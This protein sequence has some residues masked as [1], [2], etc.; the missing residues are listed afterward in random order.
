MHA[1]TDVLFVCHQENFSVS[2]SIE[3]ICC[4]HPLQ[5][6]TLSC[7]YSYRDDWAKYFWPRDLVVYSADPLFVS[8]THYVGDEYYF[9]DTEPLH[10]FKALNQKQKEELEERKQKQIDDKEDYMR[11]V[12]S[13]L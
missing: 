8:P 13:E 5:S 3:R 12:H 6:N 7:V 10:V 1:N 4:A 2:Y 9:S 11:D